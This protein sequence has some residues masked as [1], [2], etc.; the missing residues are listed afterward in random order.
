MSPVRSRLFLPSS[1][2]EVGFLEEASEVLGMLEASPPPPETDAPGVLA[3]FLAGRVGQHA[4]PAGIHLGPGH[5]LSSFHSSFR[6]IVVPI[7]VFGE[8]ASWKPEDIRNLHKTL[9]RM[10]FSN[11]IGSSPA[12]AISPQRFCT[13]APLGQDW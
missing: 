11:L 4:G 12:V 3:I 10:N 6:G 13:C 8:G 2:Y 5:L 1:R 9:A 7:A